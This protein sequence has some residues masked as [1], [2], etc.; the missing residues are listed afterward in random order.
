MKIKIILIVLAII[1]FSSSVIAVDNCTS[2]DHLGCYG[3]NAYWFDSCGNPEYVSTYC[4]VNQECIDGKCISFCGNGECQSDKNEDCSSCSQDCACADYEQCSWG[5]CKTYC[6]NGRCDGDENCWKCST[7]CSCDS[8]EKCNY[9][10]VCKTYCGNGKCDGN[11]NCQTC[12]DCSCESNEDCSPSSSNA[13]SRGCV[14]RCGNGVVDYGENCQTC[15]EDAGCSEGMQCYNNGCVE[16]FKDSHCES[17]DVPIGEFIC[18][19]D[20]K[21][22][23]EKVTRTQG[24]CSYNKCSGEKI[25]T[26]KQASYCGEKLC[27]DGECGCKPKYA[28]CQKSGKCEQQS[29]LEDGQS[30]SCYFQCQSNYC[31]PSGKCVKAINAPLTTSSELLKVGETAKITISADNALGYDIP[32][33]ITL[34]TD[35]GILMSGIVGGAD[36]SGNQ[37]TGGEIMIQSKGRVSIIVDITAQSYGKHILTATVI[38]TIGGQQ[39]PKEEKIEIVIINPIDGI[40]SEGETSQNACS[41]CGCPGS[42]SIYEYVCKTDYSCKKSIKWH[43]YLLF[44]AAIL[45]IAFSIYSVPRAKSYYLRLTANRDKR[46]AEREHNE[47]KERKKIVSALYRIKKDIKIDKPLPIEKVISKAR[48]DN[49]DPDL[50]HEEYIELLDK[51][52]KVNELS[53]DKKEEAKKILKE[54]IKHLAQRFCTGCGSPLREGTKFCTKCGRHTKK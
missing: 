8:D 48:L 47:F 50:V 1:L 27:Q 21:Y 12:H 44:T 41:D 43:L 6:G 33:K 49:A 5:T 11:E 37:C 35:S 25:E 53:G 54:P 31:D 18:S 3:G 9:P 10:G 17:R 30:C 36:C 51:M 4:N 34:N 46:T 24:I 16:C 26:T 39:Y 38:P 42:T 7:D 22:T 45:L 13:D 52:R 2:Y 28:A 14:D 15:P 32:T 23:L 40:C 29:I 19:S 20:F